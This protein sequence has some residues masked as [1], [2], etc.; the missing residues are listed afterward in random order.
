[1]SVVFVYLHDEKK[2]QLLKKF[3]PLRIQNQS[4]ERN[5]IVTLW[6]FIYFR[7]QKTK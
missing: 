4:S 3:A 2:K 7:I 5:I 6:I 1:M